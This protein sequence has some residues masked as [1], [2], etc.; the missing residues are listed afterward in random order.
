MSSVKNA[1]IAAAG[2]GSRL[3]LGMP[4]C[5]IQ[6]HKQPL[7]GRMLQL[8]SRHVSN[9]V[10]VTGYR[11][12]M[13]VEYCRNNFRDIILA[14]N[15]DFATTNTAHSLAIGSQFVQGKTIYL[16]ADLLIEEASFANFMQAACADDLLIGVSTPK[17]EHPVYVDCQKDNDG[18]LRAKGFGRET[19]TENE[20]AN[21]FVGS[22]RIMDHAQGFVYESLGRRLP[23]R[24]AF[25]ELE[26]ID[27]P[28]DMERAKTALAVWDQQNQTNSLPIQNLF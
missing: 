15:P 24:A 22:E 2:L 18:I 12:E 9:I 13:V 25:I 14:R 10:V 16:D 28:E 17:T 27:T 23:A 11:E 3:G 19:K 7:L 21:I 4:K 6:I 5:M 26:E 20:W 8:L 1:V